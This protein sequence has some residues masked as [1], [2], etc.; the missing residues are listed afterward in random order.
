MC[1]DT[2]PEFIIGDT[3]I[4]DK[5]LD[6]GYFHA[7]WKCKVLEAPFW[8]SYYKTWLVPVEMKE[9]RANVIADFLSKES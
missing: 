7:N 6:D 4:Y 1:K 8:S 9:R 2:K 5:T 3:Y